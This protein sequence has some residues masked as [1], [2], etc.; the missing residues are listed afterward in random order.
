MDRTRIRTTAL[1]LLIAGLAFGLPRAGSAQDSTP[2]PPPPADSSD[3][4]SPAPPAGTAP[5]PSTSA[6][7]A[8]PPS[9][10]VPPGRFMAEVL[11][12]TY[13]VEPGQ[14]FAL[15]LPIH[16]QGGAVA[17]HIFGD[18]SVVAGRHDIIV[19]LFRSSD[20]QYWLKRRGGHRADPIWSSSRQRAVRLDQELP[21]G[22]PLVL[23]LDNGYSLRTPKRVRVQIQLQYQGEPGSPQAVSAQPAAHAAPQEGDVVPRSNADN[24]SPPPPPPP[25]GDSK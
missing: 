17:A 20:Y 23:L 6:P 5:A 16:S 8:T 3:D 12:T 18:V 9:E 19:Q 11:D 13:F 22:T 25:P 1:V 4:A 14:F 24:E 10:S 21:Q 15:D 7:Q 2:P